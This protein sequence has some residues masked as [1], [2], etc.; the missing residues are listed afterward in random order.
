[1]TKEYLDKLKNKINDELIKFN[2]ENEKLFEEK[3]I[4]DLNILSTQFMQMH[5][6]LTLSSQY[7]VYWIITII[8]CIFNVSGTVPYLYTCCFCNFPVS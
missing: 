4:N 1:M 6:S 2:K 8:Y 5:Y 7:K 3:F